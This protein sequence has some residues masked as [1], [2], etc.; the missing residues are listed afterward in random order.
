MKTEANVFS[1]PGFRV[2]IFISGLSCFKTKDASNYGLVPV[3]LSHLS[4]NSGG[5]RTRS[6]EADELDYRLMLTQRLR[7][8][9]GCGQCEEL[10]SLQD[11]K[12]LDRVNRYALS[13][14]EIRLCGEVPAIHAEPLAAELC[15]RCACQSEFARMGVSRISE[16]GFNCVLQCLATG[17]LLSKL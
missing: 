17:K 12:C 8:V 13:I 15:C 2:I 6:F 5:S 3:P 10:K 1:F 9:E 11:H 16:K 4:W 14:L 7:L